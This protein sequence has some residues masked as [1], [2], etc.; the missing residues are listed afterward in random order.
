MYLKPVM[1]IVIFQE[2]KC[3]IL[4]MNMCYG[5]QYNLVVDHFVHAHKSLKLK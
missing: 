3:Y 1:Q 5:Q 2:T 4:V